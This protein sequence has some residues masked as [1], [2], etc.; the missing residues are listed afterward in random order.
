MKKILV[1][2]LFLS[3]WA[4]SS[5]N[6]PPQSA[7]DQT[8]DSQAIES[9]EAP[10]SAPGP[11]PEIATNIQRIK[12][13]SVGTTD[14]AS[15]KN[16]YS[17]WLNYHVVE[18]GTI[19]ATL[20]MSWGA[21]AMEGREYALMQGESGDDVYLR[22]IE[23]SMPDTDYKAMTTHG[24]NA[25]E[26]IVENPDSTYEK[27]INSPFSHVGGPMNLGGGM[28]S[29]R[30]T[31]FKGLSEEIFYFTTE[32]GDRSKSTLLT[33][34][35]DID[36]PFIMVLAGPDA[37]ELTDFYTSTFGA[38]EV[39]FIETPINVVSTAQGVSSDHLYPMGFVRL[40]EF[41]NSIEIDGYPDSTGARPVSTGEIP[42][43]VS[44][45]S[46]SVENLDLIDPKLFVSVPVKPEGL[47]YQGNRTAT[48]IGPAGELIELIE[49][50]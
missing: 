7:E 25:I 19:S 18:E 6:A 42:P 15:T 39:F 47:A 43:G 3:L 45:T 31:Q 5:E 40:G 28:S 35:A 37:R 38:L 16:L 2:L 34:R 26:M 27:L 29:I 23:V 36:R 33:P 22:A 11:T 17:E 20:A 13:A 30:A 4:C 44:I 8:I 46:F 48:I 32:T 10:V 41:S 12:I 49:E 14:V 9:L 1:S 50:K 24:W 21:E